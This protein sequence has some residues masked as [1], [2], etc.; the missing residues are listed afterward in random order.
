MTGDPLVDDFSVVGA[1]GAIVTTADGREYRDFGLANGSQILGHGH[2]LVDGRASEGARRCGVSGFRR[3]PLEH[4]AATA[5]TRQIANVD[6]AA[7]FHSRCDA[8][9]NA[10]ELA[11]RVTGRRVVIVLDGIGNLLPGRPRARRDPLGFMKQPNIGDLGYWHAGMRDIL[12]AEFNNTSSLEAIFERCGR[13]IAGVI[14][15]PDTTSVWLHIAAVAVHLTIGA[16]LHKPRQCDHCRRDT[17]W[18]AL[19]RSWRTFNNWVDTGYCG[20]R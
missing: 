3:T 17:K 8:L 12:T 6:D 7:F 9:R 2:E 1:R 14:I 4:Q 5:L 11:R 15:E 18:F 13:S 10:V 20:I 16:T 19:F